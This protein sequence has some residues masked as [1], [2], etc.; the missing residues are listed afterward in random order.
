MFDIFYSFHPS[1]LGQTPATESN[2]CV[3]SIPQTHQGAMH[4]IVSSVIRDMHVTLSPDF[5]CVP[6][7][8]IVS[9][10]DDS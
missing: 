3:G 1:F 4:N 6:Q 5:D 7:R 10:T 9:Q 8:Q 2:H